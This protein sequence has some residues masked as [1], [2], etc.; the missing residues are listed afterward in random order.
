M[1]K[2]PLKSVKGDT[3][4]LQHAGEAGSL[5]TPQGL[6]VHVGAGYK[7]IQTFWDYSWSVRHL[8]GQLTEVLYHNGARDRICIKSQAHEQESFDEEPHVSVR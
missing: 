1:H 7:R 2:Q 6:S 3:T 8:V 4:F 5:W